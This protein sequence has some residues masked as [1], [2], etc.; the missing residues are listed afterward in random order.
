MT[1]LTPFYMYAG[2]K[3]KMIKHYRPVFGDLSKYSHYA[4][5]FFG[6]GAIYAHV[7]NTVP[8]ISSTVNDINKEIMDVLRV[9]SSSPDQ[10]ISDVNVIVDEYFNIPYQGDKSS[11]KLWYYEKRK[12]YWETGD[13]ALLY[14]LMR[15]GFN[16]IWQTCKESQGKFGTPAGLLNQTRREQIINEGLIRQW[17]SALQKTSIQSTSYEQVLIPHGEDTLVF[18]DPPYR[19][20]FTT[21]STDFDDDEQERMCQWIKDMI[22]QGS[23]VTMSNRVV[24]GD[25][26]FENLLGDCCDFHYFPVTYT[27]GRRKKTDTGYEAKPAVEFLALSR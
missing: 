1:E 18:C 4:E 21:Y 9:V 20:S 8:G 11:R 25:S 16:G 10:F 13:L 19:G 17:S 26:F 15:T 24:E 5:P 22:D 27:A 14:V 3:K 12:E 2:G 7:N 23:K 6:G